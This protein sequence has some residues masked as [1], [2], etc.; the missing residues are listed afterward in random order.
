MKRSHIPEAITYQ[1]N[2]GEGI[3]SDE[4]LIMSG[5]GGEGNRL[6]C[7]FVISTLEDKDFSQ[8]QRDIAREEFDRVSDKLDSKV[9]EIEFSKNYALIKILV[10]IDTALQ[11]VIDQGIIACNLEERFLRFHFYAT[12][13]RKPISKDIQEYLDELHVQF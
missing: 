11:D 12:N 9:E 5:L 8:H 13:I 4:T 7:Y 1:D 3:F 10:S 6:R 2:S